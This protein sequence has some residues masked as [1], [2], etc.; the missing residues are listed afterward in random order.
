MSTFRPMVGHLLMSV[1]FVDG[2]AG[3]SA[4]LTSAEQ[5]SALVE[6]FSATGLL[7]RL[8]AQWGAS[9]PVPV[10]SVC[11]FTV[12]SQTI[13]LT[14]DPAPLAATPVED[15][16]VREGVWMPVALQQMGFAAATLDGQVAQLRHGL[17]TL[18][19]QGLGVADAVPLF[20]TKYPCHHPAHAAAESVVVNL[21]DTLAMFPTNLDG[22]IA[23]ET[24]HVFG[25]PDEYF[26]HCTLQQTAGFFDTPNANCN[27][28][29]P[30]TPPIPPRTPCLMDRTD[31]TLCPTTPL[32]WGWVDTNGDGLCDLAD[33][34]T[35]ELPF[36]AATIGE[37]IEIRGRN[38]WDTRIVSFGDSLDGVVGD[39]GDIRVDSPTSISVRLPN[40]VSGIVNVSL[41]TRAGVATGPPLDTWVLLAPDHVSPGI[42]EPQVFGITPS[43]AAAG[44]SVTVLG[45]NL[46]PTT[47]IL[48]GTT[49]ADLSGIDPFGTGLGTDVTVPV[50]PGSGTV[51]VTVSTAA[52]TS[53]PIPAFATFTYR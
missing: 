40:A 51:Q 42:V 11:G 26:G 34:A 21:P 30:D 44:E 53:T 47:A 49:P 20:L 1:V 31:H 39:L 28:V 3:S 7:R 33:P 13:T 38:V 41:V 17:Q 16:S 32:H 10:R 27:T 23:H 5:S 52:G 45:N 12:I 19:M 2:P 46:A 8:A 50:P 22:V 9:Q 6:V 43:T 18:T 25:A 15:F 37:R 35:I 36:H 29:G 4:A 24:G 48:F 14:T